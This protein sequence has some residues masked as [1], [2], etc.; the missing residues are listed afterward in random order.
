LLYVRI[1]RAVE[2]RP[3]DDSGR[4]PDD[5]TARARIRD[6]AMEEF[7]TRGEAGATIRGIAQRAGV[8]PALVQHHFRTKAGLREAC[9]AHVLTYLRG[10]VESGIGEG[11]IGDPSFIAA[12]Y[13]SAPPVLRYLSRALVD[14]SPAAATVFDQIVAITERYLK[15]RP[16]ASDPHT[17]AVVLAAMRLGATVLHEHVSRQLG[18]EMFGAASAPRIGRAMLDILA[19]EIVPDGIADRV[20]DGLDH[21]EQGNYQHGEDR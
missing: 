12:I 13:K 18:T 11:R 19:P 10:E 16:G 20:R 8:S 2:A 15:D 7:A 17:R 21:Y 3:D 14:G 9:D 4:S 5:L 1:V 6:A